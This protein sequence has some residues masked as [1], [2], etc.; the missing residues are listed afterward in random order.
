MASS[1]FGVPYGKKCFWKESLQIGK[2]NQIIL[3]YKS[4]FGVAVR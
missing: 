1:Y 2:T 4:E 3:V